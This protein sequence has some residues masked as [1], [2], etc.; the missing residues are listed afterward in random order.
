M[1]G[2][3]FVQ[4]LMMALLGVSTLLIFTICVRASVVLYVKLFVHDATARAYFDR[5][6]IFGV[7][8]KTLR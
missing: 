2:L 3:S 7:A 5:R 4:F 8:H 6:W 1:I